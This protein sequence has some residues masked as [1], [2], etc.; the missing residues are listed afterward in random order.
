MDSML[1]KRELLLFARDRLA[2]TMLIILAVGALALLAM[3]ALSVRV[4]DVQVPTRYS[5]YGFT[6]LYRDKWYALLAFGIFPL[7]VFFIN[8]FMAIKLHGSRRGLAL[9]ILGISVFIM[10]I[11]IIVAQAVFRLAAFSL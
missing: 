11:A 7:L 10:I 5:G 8:G 4:S 6:N 9:G 3:T 2:I 1:K